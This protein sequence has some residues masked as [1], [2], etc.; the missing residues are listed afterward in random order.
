CAARRPAAPACRMPR[1]RDWKN[2]NP[3]R[4]FCGNPW[5]AVDEHF[6]EN[7]GWLPLGTDR[8]FVAASRAAP[9]QHCP[10]VLGLH[11]RA[12]TMRFGAPSIVRL[13]GTFRHF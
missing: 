9:R 5:I 6:S 3:H 10:P 12:E 1:K 2:G 11:A 7:Q 4:K 8:E 13:K